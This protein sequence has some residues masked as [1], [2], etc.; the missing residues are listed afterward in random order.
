LPEKGNP[1]DDRSLIIDILIAEPLQLT[2]VK[3]H[4]GPVANNYQQESCKI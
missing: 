2:P 1:G 4:H 3:L